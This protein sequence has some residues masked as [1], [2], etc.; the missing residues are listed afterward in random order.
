MKLIAHRGNVD[1]KQ[2][3]R[4]NAPDYIQAAVERGF[5]VEID[6]W[7][8]EDQ[9]LLGHDEGLYPVAIDFLSNERFW[10]HCKTRETLRALLGTN[11]HC[12][13]H[14][15]DSVTLTSRGVMWAYPSDEPLPGSVCV[16]PELHALPLDMLRGC[17]G[18]CSDRIENYKGVSS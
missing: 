15:E 1:R 12:F 9:F 10:C 8:H 14:E 5:D 7:I 13:F 17:F 18:I 6:V 2:E 11:A 16:L 4:E 3:G